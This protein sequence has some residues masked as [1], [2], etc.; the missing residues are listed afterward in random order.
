MTFSTALFTLFLVMD[1]LG[2]VPAF[3]ALLKHVEPNRRQFVI[4]RECLIAFV[5]LTFFL[6]VGKSVLHA[7]GISQAAL[8]ISG[9]FILFLIAIKM[10][11]PEGEHE[12]KALSRHEPFIVPLA[13]PLVAGP[14]SMAMVM[15]LVDQNPDKWLL[16]LGAL[17]GASAI[18]T[19]IL[20]FSSYILKLFGEK[21][22]HALERLM[23]MLL[24]TLAVQM[25]LTGIETY[26]HLK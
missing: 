14:S 10:I 8:G 23:G 18:T 26:F 16:W 20:F 19:L 21:L 2:N 11:F 13:V 5:I 12:R 7:L 15:L 25:L 22:L 4:L 17:A 6:F 1:P 24:A 3:L 9:G